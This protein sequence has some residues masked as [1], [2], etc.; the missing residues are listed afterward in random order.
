MMYEGLQLDIFIREV[1]DLLLSVTAKQTVLA[2]KFETVEIL[3]AAEMYCMVMDGTDEFSSYNNFDIEVY[4]AAG[5]SLSDIGKYKADKYAIPAGLRSTILKFQRQRILENY[6]EKNNYYRMLAGL[7]DYND[8]DFIYAPENEF[9]ISTTIPVHQLDVGSVA[10]MK[11]SGILDD[12]IQAN[13]TKHYLEHLGIKSIDYY[14]ARKA[15]NYELLYCEDTEPENIALDFR[16]FYANA[17]EYYMIA[18]YNPNVANQYKYYDNFIGLC[19]MI[20]ALQRLFAS[21]FQEGITRDFYD[22]QLIRYLFNSYSI[23]YIEDMTM[24]QLKILAKNL[25][26]F[27]AYKSSNRVL[28]D[29]CSI[30]GFSNVSI[31]K[32]LLV[33]DHVQDVN[34]GKPIFPMKT[35]VASDGTI[36]K[37]FDYEDMY[38]IYFQRVDVKTK[39]V[40]TAL[41]DKS[42]R[43]DYK[44]LTT[45]DIYWV[46][47]DELREKLYTT[48]LN[49]IES[50]YMSVDMMFKITAMMYEVCHF[51]RMVID[52]NPEFRKVYVTI[53]KVSPYPHDLFSIV[54][55]ICAF[56][57]KRYGFNGEVPLKPAQIATVYGF[58]FHADLQQIAMDIVDS[59]YLDEECIQYMLNFSVASS[60]DVDRIYTN[61][62]TLKD[63]IVEQL[64]ST[65]NIE[66]YRAYKK[67][68]NTILVIEDKKEVYT[69]AAGNVYNNY[70]DLLKGNDSELYYFLDAFDVSDTKNTE[71]IMLHVLYRLENLSHN[72]K[73]LHTATDVTAL[74][75]VLLRLILFFKSY[76]VDFSHSGILY[77]FDDRFFNMIKILDGM[78]SIH[79]STWRDDGFLKHYYDAIARLELDFGNKDFIDLR[80]EEIMKVVAN[81]LDHIT[82]RDMLDGTFIDAW[83]EDHRLLGEYADSVSALV[84]INPEE[85]IKLVAEL[86]NWIIEAFLSDRIRLEENLTEKISSWIEDHNLLGQY[87]DAYLAK[88]TSEVMDKLKIEAKMRDITIEALI[89]EKLHLRED[90]V[91]KINAWI[92]TKILGQYSDELSTEVFSNKEDSIKFIAKMVDLVVRIF[93]ESH[94]NIRDELSAKID[95]RGSTK[96]LNIYAD[97]LVHQIRVSMKDDV[98]LEALLANFKVEGLLESK[99]NWSENLRSKVDAR[100]ET[101]LLNQYSDNANLEVLRYIK[102]RAKLSM[103]LVSTKMAMFLEA[104]LGLKG[105]IAVNVNNRLKTN[106]HLIHSD[107]T[108]IFINKGYDEMVRLGVQLVSHIVT[109]YKDTRILIRDASVISVDERHET[110]VN[111]LD[112]TGTNSLGA[113]VKSKVKMRDSLK[114]LVSYPETNQ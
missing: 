69:D 14:T 83:L 50:K 34:T 11:T 113:R 44:D 51:F 84:N 25:N 35:V 28:F 103:L 67:L 26:I 36:T 85:K 10:R 38:D 13:P 24:D 98:K 7:P 3:E 91:E 96:L 17:R 101:S 22:V 80:D 37:G 100:A 60:K 90:L 4:E 93:L 72:L 32:Y 64:A 29:L 97:E 15:L 27:L 81:M 109:I 106:L 1:K 19:I 45:G 87:S 66:V 108:A 40:N 49:Y 70:F 42:N 43:V 56:W 68:Y 9:G 48:Q 107:N 75:T 114:I 95:A 112:H 102:E 65:K 104:K 41:V 111:M 63:F 18:I 86:G 12:L 20:M 23:P 47:D 58:N 88:V 2:K 110:R 59:E 31:Y 74:M 55:F 6:E 8:T 71:D 92:N 16:K 89:I 57:C 30:F 73:Y 39:D 94:I 99:V 46:D 105:K 62:K 53:P 61:I 82:F 79:I 54:I 21:V 76:T 77:V 52:N 33:R 5:C 78:H